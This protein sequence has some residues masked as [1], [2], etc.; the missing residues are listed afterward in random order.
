MDLELKS[1]TA[2]VSG[3]SIGIGRAIARALAMEGVR[4][5]AGRETKRSA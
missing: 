1:R 2:V 5:G 3:A 4:G